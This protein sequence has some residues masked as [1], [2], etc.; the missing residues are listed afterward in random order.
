MGSEDMEV[1]RMYGADD[2]RTMADSGDALPDG[3]FPIKDEADLKNAIAAFGRAKDP[4]TAKAHIIKRATELNLEDMIPQA[5][6]A[7]DDA[8]PATEKAAPAMPE[9]GGI[10]DPLAGEAAA[11]NGMP[12][13]KKPT[14]MED[15][16]EEAASDEEDEKGWLFRM[17]RRR[18]FKSA[19]DEKSMADE[20]GGRNRVPDGDGDMV[21]DEE[22]PTDMATDK[23]REKGVVKINADGMVTKCAKGL[24]AADCG[25]KAGSPV[26][27]KCG[28]MAV[29]TKTDDADDFDTEVVRLDIA[30]TAERSFLRKHYLTELGTKSAD[31]EDGAFICM[32]EQKTLEAGTAPCIDCTGGCTRTSGLPDLAEV[33]AVAEALYGKVL[34]S[35]Y[36]DVADRFL[37]T[38]E[39]K[40]GLYEAHFDGRGGFQ[41]L[42]RLP[43]EW[44]ADE[45]VVTAEEAILAA[46]AQV[47]GKALSID[48]AILEGYE[49]YSIEVDG[50]DG[51]SYDVYV[52]PVSGDV[53][54]YDAYELSADEVAASGLAGK[55]LEDAEFLASL[56]EFELL[57]AEQDLPTLDQP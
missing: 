40:D 13:K 38:V 57:E 42:V 17:P 34:D 9:K 22:D 44:L 50:T 16:A 10:V 2:R 18:R 49:V 29:E 36:S 46:T 54:A 20:W 6:S 25:Y 3:S 11:G 52:D 5:W 12:M 24:A 56:M 31:I 51:K 14:D 28:A 15:D 23:R 19:E 8:E 26:C 45:P 27:G 37:V 1:K 41:A 39:R 48:A 32:M 4:A 55:S 35:G 47:E 43:E 53:L 21:G 33:E 30:D 7:G